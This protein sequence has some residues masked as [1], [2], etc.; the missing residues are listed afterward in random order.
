MGTVNQSTSPTGTVADHRSRE[1]FE[2]ACHYLP[3]GVSRNTVFRQPFPAYAQYGAGCRVI[4]VDGNPR[5]DLANN[6]ASLIHGHAY[7]AIVEAVTEQLQ[8]GTAFTLPTEAEMRFARLLCERVPVADKLR[9]VN[10]GTEAVMAAIKAARSFTR[11]PKLA[12]IEGTY[13]GTY[14]YA[15]TSQNPT[16]ETWGQV[17]QPLSVPVARGT[18]SGALQDVVVLP[19]N[20]IDRSRAILDQHRD[21]IAGILVDPMP[22]RVGL[23]PASTEFIVFLREWA[24]Q[25]GALLILDEVITL[26][27]AYGGASTWFPVS[28]DLITM[29][30]IIGGG[31]PVGAFAGREEVMEM[32]DP[33]QGAIPFPHSGTFSANPI[34]MTAG[35][36]AMEQY[37]QAA[38]DRLNELGEYTRSRI[39][40]TIQRRGADACVTGA[41]SMFRFHFKPE[42]P[43]NYRTAYTTP[44]EKQRMTRFVDFLFERGFMLISTCTAALS[45]VTERTQID[46]FIEALDEGLKADA[47]SN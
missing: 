46:E 39:A 11:R 37:D 6:M 14:D 8:R 41:G 4:D 3:G 15:E 42:P 30:K 22:H 29:G 1:L 31:F 10:S 16:P 17:D 43:R 33:R 27:M 12:K 23:I 38:V 24:D 32:L 25:N 26:R 13:H 47:D 19:F 40:E 45:T 28:P 21:S 36:V 2:Q 7:P 20:D 9:F 18:P 5:I 34:T 35:R 44:E